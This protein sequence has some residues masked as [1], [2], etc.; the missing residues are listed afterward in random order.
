MPLNT[1]YRFLT[2]D[3]VAIPG[4]W[5]DIFPDGNTTRLFPS[6][7]DLTAFADNLED[8]GWEL[9]CVTTRPNSYYPPEET[10]L[11]TWVFR[12]ARSH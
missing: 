3:E 1:E 8:E 11:E 10:P 2:H 12:R 6:R 9:I 4:Q 5:V 7:A